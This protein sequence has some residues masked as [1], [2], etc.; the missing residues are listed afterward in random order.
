VSKV[1]TPNA[2]TIVELLVQL[3]RI[4]QGSGY[5]GGL[6]PAQWNVLRYFSRANR[7]SRTVSAFAEFHATTRGTA[8]QTVKALIAQG[9][10]SRERSARDGRSAHLDLT[11][12]AKALLAR[13][14]CDD[15]VRAAGTLSAADRNQLATGLERLLSNLAQRS[16]KRRFGICTSCTHLDRERSRRKGIARFECT[17]F[18]ELLQ[19][20]EL[21]KICINFRPKAKSA[22]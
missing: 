12:T 11:D 8:S 17:L 6:T 9:Y 14:P 16:G 20:E 21:E 15:L 13:D 7:F 18:G 22:M 3:G 2:Q 4:T 19:E 1:T 5:G 10:L